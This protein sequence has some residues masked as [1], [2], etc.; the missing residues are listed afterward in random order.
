MP[1]V[2]TWLIGSIRAGKPDMG[3]RAEFGLLNA[4]RAKSASDGS[5]CPQHS[6]LWLMGIS[7]WA[8]VAVPRPL[9]E[10][11]AGADLIVELVSW[12]LV[13]I[14]AFISWACAGG[15]RSGQSRSLANVFS[16]IANR[17][18]LRGFSSGNGRLPKHSK[19]LADTPRPSPTCCGWPSDNPR[20][21]LDLFDHLHDIQ[22]P[23]S[24]QLGAFFDFLAGSLRRARGPGKQWAASG[25]LGHL[26]SLAHL[27]PLRREYLVLLFKKLL[28]DFRGVAAT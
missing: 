19:M 9:P 22:V 13:G 23:L 6:G 20:A 2:V 10:R 7:S 11:V 14:I 26:R 8:A 3:R 24:I 27:V 5:Q 21:S 28:G 18:L 4:D 25:F 15:S 1:Q 16:V 17:R 12:P